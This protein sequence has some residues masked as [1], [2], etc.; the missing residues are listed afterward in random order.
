MNNT[1]QEMKCPS[2]G[3]QVYFDTEGQEYAF[4]SHCGTQVFKEDT[5]FDKRVELE[6]H[7]LD[8]NKEIAIEQVKQDTVKKNTENVL[9]IV[10]AAIVAIIFIAFAVFG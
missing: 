10:F 6:K 7:K 5:H 9:W 1:I 4:C 3:G 8:T 2:C